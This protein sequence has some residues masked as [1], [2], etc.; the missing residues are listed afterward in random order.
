M[1]NELRNS[2]YSLQQPENVW[3]RPGFAGTGYN[4]GDEVEQR[5]QS[6]LDQVQDVSVLSTDLRKHCTDWPSLYH[7]SSVRA[8]ILRPFESRL[9]GADVLEIG[10]GCG[11]ITR[12]LAES[13]AKVVALEGSPRRAAIARARCRDMENVTV[14]TDLFETFNGPDRFDVVTLIGVFEYATMFGQG[15][16]PALTML[17]RARQWL[18]PGGHLIIAIENKL[19]LKYF[20]GAPEDHGATPM[21]GIEG[22][23]RKGEPTTYGR[24]ELKRMLA[25]AGLPGVS[26]W[27][28]FPDYKLPKVLVSE[29]GFLHETFNAATLVSQ[30]VANDVQMPGVPMFSLQRVYPEIITNGLGIDLANSLLVVAKEDPAPETQVLACYYNNSRRPCFCKSIT[31]V[32]EPNGSIAVLSRLL[33]GAGLSSRDEDVPILHEIE[34]RSSYVNGQLLSDV[35]LRILTTDQWKMDEVQRFFDKYLQALSIIVHT[36]GVSITQHAA[37]LSVDSELPGWCLDVIPQNILETEPGVFTLIDREWSSPQPVSLSMLFF[38][39]LYGLSSMVQSVA[40]PADDDLVT[41][42]DVLQVL[43]A[44]YGFPRDQN[45]LSDLAGQEDILQQFVRGYPVKA[46]THQWFDIPLLKESS[47]DLCSRLQCE[48]KRLRG[49]LQHARADAIVLHKH[50]ADEATQLKMDQKKTLCELESLQRQVYQ[51]AVSLSWRWT[52]PIRYAGAIVTRVRQSGHPIAT[53]LHRLSRPVL[54]LMRYAVSLFRKDPAVDSKKNR[55]KDV[56]AEGVRPRTPYDDYIDAQQ[57]QLSTQRELY[58]LSIERLKHRPLISIIVPVYNPS[59]EGLRQCVNSVTQQLY[60]DW[61]LCLVDDGSDQEL[62]LELLREFAAADPRVKCLFR[63]K[64]GHIAT[65]TNDGIAMATGIYLAFLDHDDRLTEDALYHIVMRI[66]ETPD[67]DLI[68]TDQDKIS[69]DNRRYEPFFK[70]DWSP[71]LLRGVMYLGHLLVAR[72]E[73]VRSVGGCDPAFN[74]VQDY[75]LALRLTERTSRVEHVPRICYHWRA[76]EGSVATSI[77]AKPDLGVLQQ[78]AAQAHLDRQGRT[79]EAVLLSQNHRIRVVPRKRKD[80]PLVSILICSKDAGDL[81]SRCL[82]S[83]FDKTQYSNFEVLV[84]D[85]GTTDPIALETFERYPIRR[86][87][88]PQAFQFSAFNNRLA[89]DAAGDYLL[90]LNND[91][92]ILDPDWLSNLLFYAE[93]PD[94]AAVGPLLLY[95]DRTVQHAGVIVGPR[96][97]ADHVMRDFPEAC[98]GYHGSLVCDR[99]VSAVTAACMM[100]QRDKFQNIGGFR[101]VF[102][103]HYEDVDLCLR[104]RRSGL[105]NIY[106]A[107]TR[108][109]HHESKSRGRYYS[110]TDRM[111]LLDQWEA[112]LSKGD[113]YYNRNFDPARV[114]YTLW[115]GGLEP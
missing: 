7:L 98:D 114:D 70:P 61:E 58:R 37:P 90:F 51:M 69:V 29:K 45:A 77:D 111:L 62:V 50:H 21:Y 41:W 27:G 8:N 96:G 11:A 38:R 87:P 28:A 84:A 78:R 100:L 79:A 59:P 52:A 104:L 14:V 107:S 92:E 85:N 54:N 47:G 75:E 15:E 3:S 65:A 71:A 94:V 63:E 105:R 30:G 9:E 93:Q 44:R 97:T 46:S 81:V 31:F 55:L 40:V 76:S 35:F 42:G 72:T 89:Q 91:T 80:E 109:L 4:D 67:V 115:T 68:Y 66:A 101:E 112:E 82:G 25:Q 19:G 36:E 22:R 24:V 88:M 13:G 17:Q 12:Y 110:Y 23:Y 10:A 57:A 1:T 26:F 103:H 32:E 2:G 108:L 99:E 5:I 74:G 106:V 39:S 43:M 73:L 49:R 86:L 48:I 6:I 83:L 20:A 102:K 95:A 53:G 56:L 60:P 18:K 33:N 113:P 16:H 64:N 34:P